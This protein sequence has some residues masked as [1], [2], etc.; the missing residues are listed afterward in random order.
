M[1]ETVA[2]VSKVAIRCALC[3]SPPG[4]QN[5]LQLQNAYEGD[6]GY[7]ASSA[8]RHSGVSRSSTEIVSLTST[9]TAVQ[10]MD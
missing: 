4:P 5:Y 8:H 9:S 2:R 6:A 1:G 10:I 3:T 7:L